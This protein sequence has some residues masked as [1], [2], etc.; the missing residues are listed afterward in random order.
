MKFPSPLKDT[1]AFCSFIWALTLQLGPV[2]AQ[3]TCGSLI[4]YRQ[5]SAILHQAP[6]CLRNGCNSSVN[7]TS[8]PDY[9]P[10]RAPCHN[11]W[12]IISDQF[13]KDWCS[14]CRGDVA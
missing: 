11:T 1:L 6:L 14:S 9:Y 8:I 13:Q 10:P 2:S 12:K 5:F 7:L 4:T 3:S